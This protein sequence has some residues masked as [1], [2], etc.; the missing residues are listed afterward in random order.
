MTLVLKYIVGKKET[1]TMTAWPVYINPN[2][3]FDKKIENR[4]TFGQAY[5]SMVWY[6]G[7]KGPL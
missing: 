3:F 1:K 4:Q 5:I 2:L 7:E 6:F